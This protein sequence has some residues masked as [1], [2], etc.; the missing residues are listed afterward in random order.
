MSRGAQTRIA[1]GTYSPNVRRTLR[2]FSSAVATSREGHRSP[3]SSLA[4]PHPSGTQYQNSEGPHYPSDSRLSKCDAPGV[5]ECRP[6]PERIAPID[7]VM[8]QQPLQ[9]KHLGPLPFWAHQRR[10]GTM[11]PIVSESAA[12]V[13]R[14]VDRIGTESPCGRSPRTARRR[15]GDIDA[16]PGT[17]TSP[18]QGV[19]GPPAN[20]Y[21]DD[22]GQAL[23]RINAAPIFAQ[24]LTVFRHG[25]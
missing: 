16:L 21:R 23:I 7:S 3:R 17:R 6:A 8:Q 11:V 10:T 12:A 20:P 25:L 4:I 1:K 22:G 15:G 14:A 9:E 5:L 19:R 24:R 18:G 13:F 2:R